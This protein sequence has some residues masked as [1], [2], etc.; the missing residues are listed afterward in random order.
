MV[1]G[2]LVLTT[3]TSANQL[4]LISNHLS[5]ALLKDLTTLTPQTHHPV[6][7]NVLLPNM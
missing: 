3:Q 7:P 5:S 1:T 6:F 2:Q 4:D